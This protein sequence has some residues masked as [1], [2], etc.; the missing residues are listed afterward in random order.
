MLFANRS[1]IL[2][3]N[4]RLLL[5]LFWILG[6]MSG[7]ALAPASDVLQ[8]LIYSSCS[9]HTPFFGVVLRCILPFLISTLILCFMNR[10][11]LFAFCYC[12]G[13]LLSL[14]ICAL[15]Q[16]YFQVS[17]ILLLLFFFSDLI[18]TPVLFYF[19]IKYI[20]AHEVSVCKLFPFLVVSILT[21]CIDYLY[22]S[23]LLIQVAYYH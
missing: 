15:T 19:W 16:S 8:N 11:F 6:L 7:T 9:V 14:C 3:S 5:S 22:I 17:W 12:K 18:L 1:A 13:F 21:A 10:S 4:S 20:D 2:S 23:P